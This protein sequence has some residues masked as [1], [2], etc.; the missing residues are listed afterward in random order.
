[1]EERIRVTL[2]SGEM[3]KNWYNVKADLP[4]KL[5]PPLNPKTGKIITPK[6][7]SAIFCPSII[8]Q[9]ATDERYIKIPEEVLREYAVFRPTPLI[10]ASF[11]EEYLGTPAKIYYKYEGAS[12]TGS[13]KTN[14]ALAQAYYN[15]RDSV[16]QLVTETGAG[17]W[18]SALTYAGVKFGLKV[19]VFMVRVSYNQK[20]MRKHMMKLFGGD[21]LESPSDETESGLRFLKDD[22]KHPGS[23]G[24][25]ISE[26][27]ETVLKSG[28]SKYA[29]GSVLDHVLL[30]QTVIGLELKKQLKLINETP[31]VIIGCHG[32]GSNFGGTILPF[33]LEKLSGQEIRFLACE[34]ESCPTLTE[35]EYRYDYGDS[36]GFTPLLKMYTLGKDFV[37]PKIHAGG[38]RYHGS[39]PIIAKLLEEKLIE[40]ENFP[41]EETFQAARLFSKVEGI[42]PAPETAHAIAGVIREALKAK[43]MKK[44]EV[45]VFTLSGH[46]LLDLSA[47]S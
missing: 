5:D 30:H 45:I 16:E 15:A 46:G 31:T 32:G 47:Y 23:L 38:L 42:I 24:I 18:G 27:I 2:P 1:M 35:G 28:K 8:E 11:L 40:A 34:P 10:R 13:H 9:E 3:I 26:A 4:F 43:T 12:P 19:R 6:E 33:V 37:P 17:Q 36:S 44:E 14:T 25:A 39:A 20:P 21:V 7:L 22:L 41:Q 29:L